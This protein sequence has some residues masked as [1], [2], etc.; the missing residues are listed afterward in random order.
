MLRK[1]TTLSTSRTFFQ[2]LKINSGDLEVVDEGVGGYA[3]CKSLDWQWQLCFKGLVGFVQ[4]FCVLE[5][6]MLQ[7]LNV[8]H[9]HPEAGF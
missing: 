3:V 2:Y 4:T 9:K 5:E 7:C 6:L 1:L 8:R